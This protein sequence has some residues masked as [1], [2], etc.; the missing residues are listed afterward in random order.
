MALYLVIVSA[1]AAVYSE[2]NGNNAS[3]TGLGVCQNI[4]AASYQPM[5]NDTPDGYGYAGSCTIFN[6]GAR[7]GGVLAVYVRDCS[8][9]FSTSQKAVCAP[10]PACPAA[11]SKTTSD[12]NFTV[13]Y[14]SNFRDDLPSIG[15]IPTEKQA[16]TDSNGCAITL[17]FAAGSKGCY[18]SQTPTAT[19]LYRYSCDGGGIYTGELSPLGANANAAP[20]ACP[21]SSGSVNG[22]PVC[23]PKSGAAVP[24][25][26]TNPPLAGN[27]PPGSSPS[28][29]AAQPYPAT[30]PSNPGSAMGS[31]T[32]G[33]SGGSA[34]GGGGTNGNPVDAPRSN[35]PSGSTGN[36][37]NPLPPKPQGPVEC[38]GPGRPA[39][40]IDETGTGNGNGAFDAA[41]KGVSDNGKIAADQIN[42][43]AS[44]S[45]KDTSWKFS[46][47]L[48]SQCS[49]FPMFM[50]VSVDFCSF[51]PM[52]HDLMSL[53]WLSTTVFVLI[54]MFGRAQ[55]GS[56]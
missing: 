20:P 32:G 35:T 19:G 33:G 27:P 47:N 13:G 14:S 48:P 18:A 22:V 8:A 26:N 2:S 12:A 9:A 21:G 15:V 37:N 43:A 38:G 44:A 40:K 16:T 11:S 42:S 46:F 36:A 51:Q 31:G 5:F 45:G 23:L 6:N 3:L 54:G 30:A 28:T 41:T 4:Y 17:D 50:G 25:G 34:G 56:A 39:C 55:R 52:V 53:V 10:P 24:S 49:V 1:S 7:T 29:E